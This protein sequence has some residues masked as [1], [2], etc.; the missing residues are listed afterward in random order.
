[1]S[2]LGTLKEIL[3]ISGC[4]ISIDGVAVPKL[5]VLLKPTNVCRPSG[6]L[7][8]YMRRDSVDP[9]CLHTRQHGPFDCP[10]PSLGFDLRHEA[11]ETVSRGST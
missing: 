3:S 9:R 7:C 2:R 1:M 4:L 8:E 6:R 5:R 11:L 10:V